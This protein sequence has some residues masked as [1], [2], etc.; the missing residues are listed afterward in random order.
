MHPRR[1]YI[2][3]LVPRSQVRLEGTE[4]HHLRHV[5]RLAEGDSVTLFDGRGGECEATIS[6]FE[7]NVAILEAGEFK[8]PEPGTVNPQPSIQL[9][10]AVCVPKGKNAELIIEKGCELG[11][12][13]FLPVVAR[14]NVLDARVREGKHLDKWRRVA[15]A[16]CK[17]CGR[18]S[19][20]EIQPV[21]EFKEVM[22]RNDFAHRW[23]AMPAP[24]ALTLKMAASQFKP[25]EK[26]L[27]L[28][29]PEGGFTDDEEALARSSG[30][31]P[32]TLGP[33]RLRVETAAI[34]IAAAVALT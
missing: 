18:N 3:G 12:A 15:I 25:G 23:I 14:R 5:L 20:L 31:T 32:V 16:A 24:D 6:A 17:Q 22:A 30:F 26:V 8:Q 9:T 11:A 7:K 34:A 28:V 1:F 33:L 13:A 21:A 2:S 4:A 29:G 27:A 10:L 19:L